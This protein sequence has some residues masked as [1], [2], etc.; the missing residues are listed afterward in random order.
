MKVEEPKYKK[1]K[2]LNDKISLFRGDITKLEVD[3]IVN[4][5]EWGLLAGLGGRLIASPGSAEPG[6]VD[7]NWLQWS[8]GCWAE[9]PAGATAVQCVGHAGSPSLETLTRCVRGIS[10]ERLAASETIS[11]WGWGELI[12]SRFGLPCQERGGQ[13]GV[14]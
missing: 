11:G 10:A 5:G 6:V 9:W 1:D 3:A 14:V 12:W 2:Q 13:S 4:A 7:T 8:S